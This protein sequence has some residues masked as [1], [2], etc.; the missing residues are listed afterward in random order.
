MHIG[1]YTAQQGVHVAK[2]LHLWKGD[3]ESKWKSCTKGNEGGLVW[4]MHAVINW[5]VNELQGIMGVIWKHSKALE[6]G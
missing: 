4:G 1:E 3:L 2:G 6:L 5:K